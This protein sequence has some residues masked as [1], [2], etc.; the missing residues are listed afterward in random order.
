VVVF[1][2][3]VGNG[4]VAG[5]IH[6]SSNSCGGGNVNDAAINNRSRSRENLCNSNGNGPPLSILP[7]GQSPPDP[8]QHGR[9]Q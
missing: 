5:K 7:A 3:P 4:A 9:D 1:Q 2:E 8:D 6:S